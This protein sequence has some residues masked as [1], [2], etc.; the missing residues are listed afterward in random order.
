MHSPTIGH[1]ATIKRIL[2]YV[3]G[4]L[5]LFQP[6]SFQLH[7]YTDS[8]WAGDPYDKRSTF[9]YYIFFRCQSY[10]LVLQEATYCV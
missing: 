9:G 6:S 10:I 4:T 2:Q 7:A 3:K 5:A 8:N 1:F